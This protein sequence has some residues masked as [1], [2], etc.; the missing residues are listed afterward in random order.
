MIQ[1]IASNDSAA[2]PV[3]DRLNRHKIAPVFSRHADLIV[4][5]KVDNV[6]RLRGRSALMSPLFNSQEKSR[7]FVTMMVPGAVSED[8][9]AEQSR[10]EMAITF[11]FSKVTKLRNQVMGMQQKLNDIERRLAESIALMSK[12]SDQEHV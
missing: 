9:D 2:F 3:D 7:I 10:L 1:K 5:L 6:V 4:E 12:G 8:G 11:Q